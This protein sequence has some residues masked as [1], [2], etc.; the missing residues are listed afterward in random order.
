MD[1]TVTLIGYPE[2]EKKELREN[3]EKIFN[4]IKK[5]AEAQRKRALAQ[6]GVRSVEDFNF[7][8]RT[9]AIISQKTPFLEITADQ[10][11][12]VFIFLSGEGIV[13]DIVFSNSPQKD[14]PGEFVPKK[15]MASGSWLGKNILA[16]VG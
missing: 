1:L 12:E 7:T 10:P 14:L 13:E 3:L 9:S 4:K 2:Q 15:R 5:E 16:K 8:L 6:K 11:K